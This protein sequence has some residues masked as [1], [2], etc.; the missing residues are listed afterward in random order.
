MRRIIFVLIAVLF[1]L[2]IASSLSAAPIIQI[3][4]VLDQP[5]LFT[6]NNDTINDTTKISAAILLSGFSSGSRTLSWTLTIRD[7]Q[8]KTVRAFPHKQTVRNNI[9]LNVYEIW[10][11]N[12]SG[13]KLVPDGKYFYTFTASILNLSAVPQTGDVTVKKNPSLSVSITPDVW[14][15]GSINTNGVITMDQAD[16]LTVKN[17]GEG[18]NSYSLYLVNP[19]GWTASQSAVGKD[20]YILNAAFSSNLR[21]IN[22]REKKHALSTTSVRATSVKFSG[23]QTGV[24]VAPGQNRTLWLQFKSP[25]LNSVVNEQNIQ[26]MVNAEVP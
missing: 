8:G 7:P 23:N 17:D 14:N 2:S 10:D 15:I 25:K 26:V 18:Y 9:S 20:I 6:P 21:S 12:N 22:W 1:F 13:R 24:K 3:S 11:G 16:K 19:P 4:S 5:D